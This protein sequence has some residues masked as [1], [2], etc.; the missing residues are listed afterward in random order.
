MNIEILRLGDLNPNDDII[1]M[2]VDVAGQDKIAATQLL[3]KVRDT[4]FVRKLRDRGFMVLLAPMAGDQKKLIIEGGK[5]T[6][7]DLP[8]EK[9][10]NPIFNAYDEAMQ[11]IG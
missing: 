3:E 8:R 1:I 10:N 7:L 4:E 6:Q 11:I 9:V 2:H 5:K